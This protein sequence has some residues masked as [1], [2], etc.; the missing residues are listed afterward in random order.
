MGG[1][2]NL[3]FSSHIFH[4]GTMI[5]GYTFFGAHA[6]RRDG[7]DGYVFR[8]WAPH[9]K[10]VSVGG[11]FNGWTADADPMQKVEREIWE[12]FVPGLQQYDLY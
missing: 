5:H 9:A 3:S 7:R 11:E 8:T 1:K 6:E 2:E 10:R 4:E 12:G